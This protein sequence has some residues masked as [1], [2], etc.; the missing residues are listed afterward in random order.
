LGPM[1]LALRAPTTH[2][3]MKIARAAPSKSLG[4]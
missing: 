3:H 4:L 1:K 2:R